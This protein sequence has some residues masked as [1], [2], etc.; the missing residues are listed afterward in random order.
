MT[1]FAYDRKDK[2]RESILTH[3]TRPN[4]GLLDCIIIVNSLPVSLDTILRF[5]IITTNNFTLFNRM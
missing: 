2:L 4:Y 5:T 3:K 1:Y